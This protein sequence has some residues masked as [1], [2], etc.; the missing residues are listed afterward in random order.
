M[1]LD[2]TQLEAQRLIDDRLRPDHTAV[3]SQEQ[4]SWQG[5]THGAS[6]AFLSPARAC[7]CQPFK[8]VVRFLPR[9]CPASPWRS[10]SPPS[11]SFNRSPDLDCDSRWP[12][13]VLVAGRKVCGILTQI[14]GGVVIVGDWYQCSNQA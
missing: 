4:D 14:H 11:E 10:A 8:E 2:S 5:W 13:D 1:T 7:I 9:S 3:V 6:L 12:N